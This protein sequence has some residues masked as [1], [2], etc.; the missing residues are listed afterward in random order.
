MI[1]D[2]FRS[3]AKSK[4]KPKKAKFWK[5]QKEG[6]GEEEEQKTDSS[7]LKRN[8]R[9]RTR[10][11]LLA[12]QG[13][14]C[15]GEDFLSQ[16]REEQ[17][18]KSLKRA[19]KSGRKGKTAKGKVKEM[20]DDPFEMAVM[21]E[22]EQGVEEGNPL[23]MALLEEEEK[24]NSFENASVVDKD[25]VLGTD[26]NRVEGDSH[27]PVDCPSTPKSRSSS[28]T[29]EPI[30]W[31]CKSCTFLNYPSLRS[32]EI[33]DSPRRLKR[34]RVA[35]IGEDQQSQ[36]RT[37][38]LG[39]QSERIN[40][41]QPDDFN[42]NDAEKISQ[43]TDAADKV[44]IDAAL[45]VIADDRNDISRSNG[46]E[47]LGPTTSPSQVFTSTPARQKIFEPSKLFL[48]QTPTLLSQRQPPLSPATNL[49]P[50][51]PLLQAQMDTMS[52]ETDVKNDLPPESGIP[53]DMFDSWDEDDFNEDDDVTASSTS[54]NQQEQQQQP[55]RVIDLA[56]L[57]VYS[58][59]LFF[60]SRNTERIYVYDSEQRPLNINFLPLDVETDNWAAIPDVL[61]HPKHISR[62]RTFLREWNA[63]T[64]TKKRVIKKVRVRR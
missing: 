28:S 46:D 29:N 9:K 20:L 50:Q 16:S 27:Q 1:T 44:D 6:E 18:K 4:E 21:E 30:R 11:E 26:T 23:E 19:N 2:F 49:P 25:V 7:F 36:S 42:L 22:E 63:L 57:P 64:E 5:K 10:V 17:K 41:N 37:R 38:G 59:F 43:S 12:T 40:V 24:D 3:G 15:V 51:P 31:S 39:T 62:L 47:T 58:S 8:R 45:Q 35:G 33:C 52:E 54:N 56:K 34:S 48:P 13:D 60:V 32:C 14:S 55:P 53:D 61:L